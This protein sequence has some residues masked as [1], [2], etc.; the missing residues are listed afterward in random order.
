MRLC[1]CALVRFGALV[2][3]CVGAVVVRWC[4]GGAGAGRGGYGCLHNHLS[5]AFVDLGVASLHAILY[6]L[7]YT[8]TRHGM[9]CR[10]SLWRH[11]STK[12]KRLTLG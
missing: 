12:K 4:V 3:W 5:L 6:T 8:H 11:S 1:V 7:T 2:R 10:F 9:H